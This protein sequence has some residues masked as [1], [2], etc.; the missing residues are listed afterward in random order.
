[1]KVLFSAVLM[2]VFC[3]SVSASDLD[4]L[5][6]NCDGCHGTNGVSS[7]SDIP[8]IAGQPYVVIEGNLIAFRANE[9]ECTQSAYRHGDTSR[10]ATTMS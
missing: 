6:A 2:L 1:M 7:D 9:R 3:G 5:V 8:I 4:T 10:P